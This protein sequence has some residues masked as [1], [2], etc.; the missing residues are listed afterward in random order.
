VSDHSLWGGRFESGPSEVLWR[1]TASEI[2]RR[3]LPDDIRGSVAHVTMLGATGILDA[4]DTD[5]LLRALEQVAQEVERGHFTF[6]ETD[7]DVHTAVER[8]V[9]EL[10]GPVGG[11]LHTGR[12][13]NDQVATDLR[14]HLERQAADRVGGI[15]VLV[16][17]LAG[18]AEE[19]GDTIVPSFTHHQQAQAVPLAHHLLAHAWALLRDAERFEDA[20]GRIARSP[21]GAG[22]SGGS[23][24]P[25]D[26]AI[27]TKAL[28]WDRHFENSMD[29]VASRDFV[30]EYGF[31]LAQCMAHLSRLAEELILWTTTEFGW[32]MYADDV[33][34][35][36]SAM[37]QKKN[38]DIAEL[39]RGRSARVIAA[40]NALLTLQKGLSLTY[41]RDLQEDKEIVFAAD[42]LLRDTLE[43]IGALLSSATFDPPPPSSWV[44]ALD[45][46]EA[47]AVRGVP[48][49]EAHHAVGAVVAALSA[50]GRD[51]GEATL[52]DLIAA[53]ER[54]EA[55]DLEVLDPAESVRR[56]RS[57][58]GGSFESVAAQLEAIRSLVG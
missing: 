57:I 51:L 26:P 15:H 23:M 37:P 34:T 3:M 2:D 11:K 32:A 28:G 7:E 33:T 30:S 24:F 13:R 56:R 29:A 41:F 8:R 35:G 1:Y 31:V 22:A 17:V 9:I 44:T 20:V 18:K 42:D 10:A 52:D 27:S 55:S 58:G 54:F 40:S 5:T 21:L 6:A 46:A 39:A 47:L 45:L 49:R 48:F 19:V 53:D 38:P 50:D 43:A 12:S 36:S 16:G 14:L 4:S 25:L